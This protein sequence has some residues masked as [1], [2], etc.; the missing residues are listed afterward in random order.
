MPPPTP[1]LG[2]SLRPHGILGGWS[3]EGERENLQGGRIFKGTS[4]PAPQSVISLTWSFVQSPPP[5]DEPKGLV[6]GSEGTSL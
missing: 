5:Q 1:S 3:S 6:L 2:G 4:V